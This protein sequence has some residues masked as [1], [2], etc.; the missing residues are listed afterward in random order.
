M[1]KIHWT[2]FPVTSLPLLRGSYRP[3]NLLQTCYGF[4]TGKSP[5]WTFYGLAIRNG[6]TGIMDSLSFTF[7]KFH[8]NDLLPTSP[9]QIGNFPVYGETCNGFWALARRLNY[10]LPYLPPHAVLLSDK[11]TYSQSARH[12]FWRGHKFGGSVPPAF[13][14]TS[15]DWQ[16]THNIPFAM[17]EL[18]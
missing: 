12:N 13:Q 6:E 8:Y 7:P 4:A 14:A 15:L 11:G 1:P 17:P 18:A 5:T 16:A 9:Q 2:S 10:F 3:T